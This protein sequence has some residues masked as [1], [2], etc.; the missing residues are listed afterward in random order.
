[1]MLRRI[2][3]E[4]GMRSDYRREFWRFAWPRLIRGDIETVIRV[5]LMAHHMILSARDAAAGRQSASHYSSR[6]AETLVAAAE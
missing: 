2:L 1:H 5:G 4:A 3:W 6:P